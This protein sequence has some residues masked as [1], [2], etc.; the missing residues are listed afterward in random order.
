VT[1]AVW[2]LFIGAYSDRRAVAVFDSE[3]Q[4]L[5]AA[6]ALPLRDL[7]EAEVEQYRV[8]GDDIA[9]L[10]GPTVGIWRHAGEWVREVRYPA[11]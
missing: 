6:E 10:D 4:A 3:A 8:R 5:R 11:E 7:H 9:D 2:V 1:V